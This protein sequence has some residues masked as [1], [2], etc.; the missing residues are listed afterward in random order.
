[1][2]LDEE[3]LREQF[4]A[5][6]DARDEQFRLAEVGRAKYDA[7]SKQAQALNAEAKLVWETEIK[8]FEN[9]AA[10]LTNEAAAL[11]RALKGKTGE[12]TPK[13]EEASPVTE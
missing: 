11:A 6:M 4:H 10:D 8:D 7:L 12:R 13:G 2:A 9:Q 5:A 3:Q 1:M